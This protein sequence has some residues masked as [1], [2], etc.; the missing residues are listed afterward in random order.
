MAVWG[1]VGFA[2]IVM[3][4]LW[5]LVPMALEAPFDEF[6]AVH[7]AATVVSLVAFGFGEG[8]L[9]IQRGFLPRLRSRV[10]HLIVSPSLLYGLL[11]PL[12]GMGLIGADWRTL[13][14]AWGMLL[15][16]VLMILG[17]R[18]VPS[19]WREIVILGVVVAL[20]WA[21]LVTLREAWVLARG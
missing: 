19:P 1:L 8:V 16:I 3:R 17:M 13:A 11:A 9:A 18:F 7:W 14:R 2:L 6:T 21:I 4:G 10:E 12:Y 5:R 15:A 20:A